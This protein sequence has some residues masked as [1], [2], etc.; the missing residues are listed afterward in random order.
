MAYGLWVTQLMPLFIVH[1]YF[2][3]GQN[4]IVFGLRTAIVHPEADFVAAYLEL[5]GFQGELNQHLPQV[6]ASA[7]GDVH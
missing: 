1:V 4:D 2:H 7:Q 3:R 6:M 5:I